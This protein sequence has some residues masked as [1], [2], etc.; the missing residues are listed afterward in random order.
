MLITNFTAV[1]ISDTNPAINV[2]RVATIAV[3]DAAVSPANVT[4][5]VANSDMPAPAANIATPITPIAPEKANR[6]TVAGARSNDTAAKD[7]N[8]NAIP[9][10]PVSIGPHP[11]AANIPIG[12]MS[13]LRATAMA[14][15]D[16]APV[17][18]PDMSVDAAP[19]ANRAADIPITPW[20]KVSKGNLPNANIGII[21]AF[22]AAAMA[23]RPTDVDSNPL[24]DVRAENP[25]I[26][27]RIAVIVPRPTKISEV[28]I[29]E[30]SLIAPTKAV[31]LTAIASS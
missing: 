26:T 16:A 9:A 29:I 18:E 19:N 21:K 28:L 13:R 17:N 12:I 20:I 11:M 10:I 24:S 7:P 2:P 22:M 3:T 1:G 6:G 31:T 25:A 30:I 23:T 15:I 8:A 27:P 14:T 5:P 4:N